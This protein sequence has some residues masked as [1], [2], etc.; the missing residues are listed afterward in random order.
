MIWRVLTDVDTL[1][2]GDTMAEPLS[3]SYQLHPEI[4]ISQ[5]AISNTYRLKTRHLRLWR[6]FAYYIDIVW[7]NESGIWWKLKNMAE[8]EKKKEKD[9]ARNKIIWKKN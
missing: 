3:T 2:T 6:Y 4:L 5:T 8:K 1:C 7:T 9:D